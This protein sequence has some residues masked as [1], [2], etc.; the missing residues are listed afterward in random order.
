MERFLGN[1]CISISNEYDERNS[2]SSGRQV[3]EPGSFSSSM[4]GVT[5]GGRVAE[6][7][8]FY[9]SLHQEQLPE[10]EEMVDNEC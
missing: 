10:E 9:P 5:Q 8:R 3:G 7:S 4:V 1:R 2:K 6:G